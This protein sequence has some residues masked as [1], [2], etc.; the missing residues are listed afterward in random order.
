MR[1]E[2]QECGAVSLGGA[3]PCPMWFSMPNRY[4]SVALAAALLLPFPTLADGA[5][6]DS[7]F[8]RLKAAATP[9]EAATLVS[10]IW[11]VW[12]APP[13]G[14][15]EVE[16]L[17]DAAA[18]YIRHEEY[19]RAVAALDEAIR[20]A[21]DYAEAFNRRATAHFRAGDHAASMADIAQTLKREPRHFGALSGLGM[22]QLAQGRLPEALKAYEAALDLNPH[23]RSAKVHADAIRAALK[24]R[25]L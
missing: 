12:A 19:D 4:A 17:M 15:P 16:V 13:P 3:A 25:E 11:A 14:A 21:P 5:R 8:A 22:V 1:A 24:E 7:L 10:E 6:L 18:D 9:Q 23:L 20:L 2:V